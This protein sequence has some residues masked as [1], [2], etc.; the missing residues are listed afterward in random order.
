MLVP[1]SSV[2]TQSTVPLLH[3]PRAIPPALSSAPTC[4]SSR[5]STVHIRA[6]LDPGCSCPTPG[7]HPRERG[8]CSAF[9]GPSLPPYPARPPAALRG[10]Q[11][12]I[13]VPALIPD[14]RA[15][16]QGRIPVNGAPAPPSAGHPSRL[17]QRAHLL[18]FAAFNSAYPCQP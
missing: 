17:I 13:S 11:Q 6:S 10:V 5:R 14:A 7:S 8:P 18:L 4:C 3:L 9:R 2:A 1:D 16:L 15:R 12:C